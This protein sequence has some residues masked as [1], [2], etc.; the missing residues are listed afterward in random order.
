MSKLSSKVVF[1][2]VVFL[3]WGLV[4]TAFAEDGGESGQGALRGPNNQKVVAEVNG[5][6]IFLSNLE[7][8]LKRAELNLGHREFSLKRK[9][10]IQKEVLEKIISKELILQEAKK[11]KIEPELLVKKEIYE[12]AIP[13]EGEV[14]GYYREHPDE[15]M[16]PEGVRLRHLLVRVDPS[17]S[18]EGWKAGFQKALELSKRAGEG[19]DFEKL[20]QR[21]SDPEAR[22]FGG[23]MQ[24]QYKGQMTMNEFEKAAFSLKENEVSLPIQTL[25]GFSLIQVVEKIP[26][27][28]FSFSEINQEMLK[29][30]VGQEKEIRIS[31]SWIKALR[32][33][34]NIKY[35]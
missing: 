5:Q 10:E 18:N 35:Y 17:S 30:K 8:E 28:P 20:V 7:Q 29:K 34:A 33:Q 14:A 27:K 23:D 26:P 24:I 3:C 32:S 2:Y 13:S 31:E 4:L 21:H 11:E 19:E 9:E 25:Y 15:F 22:Y 6:P 1:F 12:K 16:R